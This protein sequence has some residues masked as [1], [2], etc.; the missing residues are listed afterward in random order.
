MKII[1]IVAITLCS[2]LA[3]ATP[4]E[5]LNEITVTKEIKGND[6]KRRSHF[7]DWIDADN[8]SQ[9]T[10][11][12]VLANESLMPVTWSN[13]G[14]KVLSGLWYDPFTDKT[15]THPNRQTGS[16]YAILQ[17]DHIV[18]LKEAWQSGAK[19]WTKQ[20]RINYSNDMTNNGHLIAVHGG[21]NGSK[22][23]KD[24]AEW[25]PPNKDFHCGYALTWTAIKVEWQLTMDQTEFDTI[26]AILSGC[27]FEK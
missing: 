23:Y 26:K 25:M 4:L 5:L 6:Y 1:A 21:T 12:E 8:D 20:Q 15:F 9:N 14:K 2:A 18:P 27:K 10:R 17:I 11:Q 22:G 13:D 19:K 24:P 7:G 16:K 3:K